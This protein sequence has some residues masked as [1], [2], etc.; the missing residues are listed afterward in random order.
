MKPSPTPSTVIGVL[1][2]FL[3]VGMI[4]FN[5]PKEY[6]YVLPLSVLP[7]LIYSRSAQI[8]SNFQQGTTGQL[9]LITALLQFLGGLARVFTTIQEVGW[10]LPLLSGFVVSSVLSGTLIAQIVYYSYVSP[11]GKKDKKAKQQ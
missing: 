4:S 3:L 5:L 11:P 2:L 9:S 1:T 7:M 8:V 10:D 6:W